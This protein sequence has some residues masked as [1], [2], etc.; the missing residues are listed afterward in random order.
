[1]NN[2]NNNY[3]TNNTNGNYN[4]NS[5]CQRFNNQLS[6][7]QN[8]HY[9]MGGN[10][11]FNNIQQQ[12]YEGQN[13]NINNCNTNRNYNPYSNN[14]NYQNNV[15][16]TQR[17]FNRYPSNNNMP[18]IS[19]RSQF[20]PMNNFNIMGDQRSNRRRHT[21]Y[22][23]MNKIE[24]INSNF[25]NNMPY[26]QQN[27]N[28]N[29]Y[30]T[31]NSNQMPPQQFSNYQVPHQQ[32]SNINQN[33]NNNI[34]NQQ[35]FNNNQNNNEFNNNLDTNK[36]DENNNNYQPKN[37]NPLL[38]YDSIK[39]SE[40]IKIEPKKNNQNEKTDK[41]ND[42]NKNLPQL[43]DT[44]SAHLNKLK[45]DNDTS[46]QPANNGEDKAGEIDFNLL[47]SVQSIDDDDLNE[48][49]N[50]NNNKK[51]EEDDDMYSIKKMK[52]DSYFPGKEINESVQITNELPQDI[53]DHPLSNASLADEICTL[54]ADKKTC[55]NGKKCNKCSLIICEACSQYISLYYNFKHDHPLYFL[56][57]GK[58]VCSYC[59][60]NFADDYLFKCKQCDFGICLKCFYPDRK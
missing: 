48:D 43:D 46:E 26:Q 13:S 36:N 39:I 12:F 4:N 37:S 15:P 30:Q 56:K 5:N 49:I 25:Y 22:K 16:N 3:N 55:D 47:E 33:N 53:H 44:L 60:K 1:M 41:N 42:K 10:N 50:Q 35:Q 11:N 21:E 18:Q 6:S 34:N 19:Q 38:D 57:E 40:S 59:K 14:N 51:D 52:N 7:I 54:C 8:I 9:G 27:N 29:N 31:Q 24:E 20:N 32:Y 17:N 23:R 2:S 28:F 58:W 45:I